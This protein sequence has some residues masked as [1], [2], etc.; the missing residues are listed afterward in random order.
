MAYIGPLGIPLSE[1]RR[2]TDLDRS[3]ALAWQEREQARCGNCGTIPREWK[4]LDWSGDPIVGP[5][6]NQL[7]AHEPPFLIEDD[8]CPCCTDIDSAHQPGVPREPGHLFRFR[9]NPAAAPQD[10]PPASPSGAGS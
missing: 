8:W 1:W 3:A 2:W 4:A 10:S 9:P 6:G 5:D 7:P